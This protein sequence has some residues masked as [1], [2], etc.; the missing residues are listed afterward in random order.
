MKSVERKV[1]PVSDYFIYTPSKFA[2]E[3][4]LYPMQCGVFTYEPGY[5]LNRNSFEKLA[6]EY[7]YI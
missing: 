7:H 5:M 2:R 3:V 4:F 1:S 6:L